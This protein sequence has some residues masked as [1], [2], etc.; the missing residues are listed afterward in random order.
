VSAD[1]SHVSNYIETATMLRL[2]MTSSM[3]GAKGSVSER[4]NRV[5]LANNAH[6][7]PANG[8]ANLSHAGRRHA[9][10]TLYFPVSTSIR[11]LAKLARMTGSYGNWRA[12]TKL[13]GCDHDHVSI[14]YKGCGCGA[15]D[16]AAKVD[17]GGLAVMEGR[18]HHDPIIARLRQTAGHV[19]PVRSEGLSTSLSKQMDGATTIQSTP[20]NV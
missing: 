10:M 8:C 2:S 12:A 15:D 7:S 16:G 11:Q 20:L 14:R 1:V 4:S 5:S 19:V 18:V 3:A 17:V 9:S 13:A 6:F